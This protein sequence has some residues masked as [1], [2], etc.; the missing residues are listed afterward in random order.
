MAFLN[1]NIKL[2][3]KIEN[4]SSFAFLSNN[5]FYFFTLTLLSYL[6]SRDT[7]IDFGFV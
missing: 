3:Q 7:A 5:F 2:Y 1:Y 6:L 4:T